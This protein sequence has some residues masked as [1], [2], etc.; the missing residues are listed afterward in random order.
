MDPDNPQSAAL[1]GP[2]HQEIARRAYEISQGP[3]PGDE[4]KN[5]LLAERELR[6][7][8]TGKPTKKRAQTKNVSE[9][10]NGADPAGSRTEIDGRPYA[11]LSADEG[12]SVNTDSNGAGKVARQLAGPL[13]ASG[14][15]GAVP[16]STQAPVGAPIGGHHRMIDF[17]VRTER[18]SETRYA[19]VVEG[20]AD[21][22][23]A[24]QF[25]SSL[26]AALALGATGIVVDLTATSFIDSTAL[27]IL[28][29][30][31]KS[32]LERGGHLAVV[33]IDPAIMKVFEITGLDRVLTILPTREAAAAEIGDLL[34]TGL[35]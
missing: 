11:T 32:L 5:W 26:L 33:C 30:A 19:V 10:K 8:D 25:Q 2:A 31:E 1:E 15:T 22:C 17:A 34:T 6:G 24:P 4:R 12:C 28:I 16:C 29:T 20:E 9:A 14:I 27:R 7:S 21:M 35:T 13:E 3:D 18:I 23:T